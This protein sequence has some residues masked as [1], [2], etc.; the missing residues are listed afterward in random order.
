MKTCCRAALRH[1][2]AGL[3]STALLLTSSTGIAEEGEFPGRALYAQVKTLSTEDFARDF[4]RYT[5]IDVRSLFEYDTL[6]IQGAEHLP[7]YDTDFAKKAIALHQ[8]SGKELVF[9][10]N[11]RTC[12]KS[13]IAVDKVRAADMNKGLYAYDAGV[14]DWARAQPQRTVL[15]G[16][17]LNDPTRLLSKADIDRHLL[18][19]GEF[20]DRLAADKQALVVDIRSSKQRRFVGLFEFREKHIPLERSRDLDP[21]VAKAIAEKRPL[22]VYD[23]AGKQ[24]VWLQYYLE[25]K[26]LKD[27]YFMR[28]GYRGYFK[29]TQ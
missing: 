22:Y 13:Y 18:E 27:Y 17:S 4:D 24:V 20:A 26:G 12:H 21:V 10:C 29:N 5:V 1:A 3:L 28:G 9:Y 16:E 15:L 2:L 8:S 11:G 7:V 25:T 14:M 6:H 19:P 23:M